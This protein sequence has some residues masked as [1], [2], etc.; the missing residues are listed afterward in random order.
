MQ[1]SY[2]LILNMQKLEHTWSHNSKRGASS[3]ISYL[4]IYLTS[5][6][7]EARRGVA[8]RVNDGVADTAWLTN[9]LR[10]L[11]AG[12]ERRDAAGCSSSD[13]SSAASSGCRH[14]GRA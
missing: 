14:G 5:P 2:C 11:S 6:N 3:R 9:R 12:S 13:R 8:G 1:A 4:E 10:L 7:R